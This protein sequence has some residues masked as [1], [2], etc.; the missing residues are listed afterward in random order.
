MSLGIRMPEKDTFECRRSVTQPYSMSHNAREWDAILLRRSLPGVMERVND[1]PASVTVALRT[2]CESQHIDRQRR[3][4]LGHTQMTFTQATS[5]TARGPWW[6][7]AKH[8]FDST[9]RLARRSVGRCES[10]PAHRWTST[11]TI[12]IRLVVASIRHAESKQLM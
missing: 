10:S 7:I 1:C 2:A 6:A 12:I 4:R 3:E 5:S 9:T 8:H 11:A